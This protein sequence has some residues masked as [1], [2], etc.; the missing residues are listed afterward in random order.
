M[1]RFQLGS[2]WSW[3]CRGYQTPMP[4]RSSRVHGRN[5]SSVMVVLSGSDRN[6]SAVLE[7]A[8][9]GGQAFQEIDPHKE[10]LTKNLKGLDLKHKLRCRKTERREFRFGSG[11]DDEE[12]RRTSI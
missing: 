3:L 12:N 11:V 1:E 9:T 7:S 5:K 2:W 10:F 6:R 8:Q 4:S